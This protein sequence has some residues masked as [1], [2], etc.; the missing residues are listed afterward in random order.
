MPNTKDASTSTDPTYSDFFDSNG[1]KVKISRYQL[2]FDT[3]DQPSSPVRSVKFPQI[4]S[5]KKL[6]VKQCEQILSFL[7]L[8]G[9][10]LTSMT[11]TYHDMEAVTSLL[12]EKER[13]LELAAHI[14]QTLLMKNKTVL[15]ENEILEEKLEKAM[16]EASQLKHEISRKDRLITMYAENENSPTEQSHERALNAKLAA[17]LENL[18]KKIK[19]LEEENESLID[20]QNDLQDESKNMRNKEEHLITETINQ[21][22]YL[23][24]EI[25]GANE[26][27]QIVTEE[28]MKRNQEAMFQQDNIKLLIDEMRYL[29]DKH[30][31][32]SEKH[33][34]LQRSLNKAYNSQFRL[35][36]EVQTL[37]DKYRE[38]LQMLDDPMF[39]VSGVRSNNDHGLKGVEQHK[40]I[41]EEFSELDS[42]VKLDFSQGNSYHP[43]IPSCSR[44]DKNDV[45]NNKGDYMKTLESTKNIN[46]LKNSHSNVYKQRRP[47]D[48][49]IEK[50][51]R[52]NVVK[53]P[54][55][56]SII[57]G[58]ETP[59]IGR[60]GVPGT[61]DLDVA[62]K[63]LNVIKTR[64]SLIA[65]LAKK[66][67]LMPKRLVKESQK[68]K[69]QGK[70]N[71]NND[72]NNSLKKNKSFPVIRAVKSM[73]DSATLC[74]W[75][76]MASSPRGFSQ[77][78]S[79]TPTSDV[80]I[81]RS[82]SM[83][84]KMMSRHMISSNNSSMTSQKRVNDVMEL[85]KSCGNFE[86]LP[87]S[88]TKPTTLDLDEVIKSPTTNKMKMSQ[89]K[90]TFRI[91]DDDFVI[92][93]PPRHKCSTP[94]VPNIS[95]LECSSSQLRNVKS[96]PHL[97]GLAAA[98]TTNNNNSLVIRGS[99]SFKTSSSK[100]I[101]FQELHGRAEK[102]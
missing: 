86:V 20:R 22:N 12:E 57:S 62:V 27:I 93:S 35:S 68:E 29:Q 65:T 11:N 17:N 6:S 47:S 1:N 3:S 63:K 52:V 101:L 32:L 90:V 37:E 31:G 7:L 100:S 28:L 98:L 67:N 10:R 45:H 44:I 71:K 55:L 64:I 38:V 94:K 72:S 59:E 60:P 5:F 9:K 92:K 78:T 88:T 16:E 66:I 24:S 42:S 53:S 77:L 50:D 61:K 96:S 30:A 73:Q 23:K 36:Q 19:E 13:D 21:I 54:S 87:G 49:V 8:G 25:Q 99:P 48:I 97:M 81:N 102:H 79:K 74:K 58:L 43:D 69:H 15:E 40:S 14:G 70:N 18:Q 75:K 4:E 84:A 89:S 33:E 46:K 26:Q 91:E 80:I 85:P 76:N 83:T 34:E 41:F 51:N 56:S 2:R 95:P 82:T 39:P